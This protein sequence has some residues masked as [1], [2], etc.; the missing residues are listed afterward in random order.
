MIELEEKRKISEKRGKIVVVEVLKGGAKGSASAV[1][2]TKGY[3]LT[4]VGNKGAVLHWGSVHKEWKT[5][6]CCTDNSSYF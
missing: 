1:R 5:S 2:G 6:S 4:S 3:S